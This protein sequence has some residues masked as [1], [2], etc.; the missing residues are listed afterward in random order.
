MYDESKQY[1]TAC[2][3]INTLLGKG[4]TKALADILKTVCAF[5]PKTAKL[6]IDYCEQILEV[7]L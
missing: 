5:N 6:T 2:E 7:E 1:Q 3:Y 4:N